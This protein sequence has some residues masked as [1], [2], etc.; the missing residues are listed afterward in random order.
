MI[1]LTACSSQT[2]RDAEVFRENWRAS[3]NNSTYGFWYIGE[4]ATTYYISED[5]IISSILY[6]VPK[7]TILVKGVKP[8]APCKSCRG[9]NLHNEN[10]LFKWR[11]FITRRSKPFR[12]SASTGHFAAL[13]QNAFQISDIGLCKVSSV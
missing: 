8:I 6:E 5:R 2:V 13:L 1:L 9:E 12:P 3:G 7:E 10:I 4:T 11:W